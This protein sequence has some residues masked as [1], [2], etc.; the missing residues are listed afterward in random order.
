[1]FIH[2]INPVLLKIGNI[3]IRYYGLIYAF[4][5]L[6]AYLF[7]KKLSEER[8]INIK[9]EDL[10]SF[11]FYLALGTIIG[12]RLF[13]TIFYNIKFYLNSPLDI[14]AL[15]HGGMSFHGGLVGAFIATYLFCKKRKLN[16]LKVADII[17]IPAALA[18]FLGR[19]GNFLNGELYGRI[20]DLPWAV[21]FPNAEGFRHPSQLYEALKNL[22]I[23]TILWFNRN[24][25]R[26][27]G[28][29]FALFLILYSI[30]RFLIEFVREP[31]IYVGF[32]TM[33]QLLTIPLF[34]IGIIILRKSK[35][36]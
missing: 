7:I 27:Y 22:L 34:I 8:R 23:F 3:E 17:V 21:K 6:L 33:G 14:F 28:Y 19:I 1:M 15:W 11:L 25:N 35:S 13:Y 4:G 2:N 16:F 26:P 29:L 12:A 20:A 32:L 24:K 9:K 31:E 10:E 18:L 30:F 5:F 36:S